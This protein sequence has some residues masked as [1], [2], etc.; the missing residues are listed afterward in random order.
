MYSSYICTNHREDQMTED[1]AQ[2]TGTVWKP[3]ILQR[4]ETGLHIGVH[5]VLEANSGGM[6]PGLQSPNVK[7]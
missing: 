5:A 4:E 7:S 6:E 3:W 1:P 2:V